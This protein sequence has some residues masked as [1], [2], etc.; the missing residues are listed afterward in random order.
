MTHP[1]PDPEQTWQ[2]WQA[3]RPGRLGAFLLAAS[4][5]GW[6]VRWV[7]GIRSSVHT[8]LLCA[9][10]LIALLIVAVAAISLQVLATMGRHNRSLDE[11]QD[12]KSTRLNSSHSR[13]SRMPSSA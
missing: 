10:L 6:L 4:P 12:R 9:F 1:P 2:S 11:A 7:A 13:A 3:A 8:K 5:L